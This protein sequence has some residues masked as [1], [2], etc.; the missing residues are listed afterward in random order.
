MYIIQ[1]HIHVSSK[2]AVW[3]IVSIILRIPMIYINLILRIIQDIK[4]VDNQSSL[5]NSKT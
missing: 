5:K 1:G 4:C 3:T 2:Y